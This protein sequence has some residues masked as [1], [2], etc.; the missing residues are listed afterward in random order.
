MSDASGPGN[1]RGKGGLTSCRSLNSGPHLQADS[2]E[3]S[4]LF[5]GF[6]RVAKPS[7][8]RF[9]LMGFARTAD[10]GQDSAAQRSKVHTRNELRR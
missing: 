8:Y 3:I 1:H 10:E 4:S 7:N 2:W 9:G 5:E 6:S